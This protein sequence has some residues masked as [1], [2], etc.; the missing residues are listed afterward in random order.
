MIFH[1]LLKII[2]FSMF[3]GTFCW[4]KG[5]CGKE[6]IWHVLT[7]CHVIF[8]NSHIVHDL[9]NI[10]FAKKRLRQRIRIRPPEPL[11]HTRFDENH[12][13]HKIPPPPKTK[14]R[15]KWF[16][17][18]HKKICWFWCW[19]FFMIYSIFDFIL[20]VS[21]TFH[22]FIWHFPVSFDPNS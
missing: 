17:Y 19:Y 4:R 6:Y 22:F 10:Y 7:I 13:T 15:N 20:F 3:F 16:Y 11:N 8:R 18:I 5:A 2:I 14:I 1:G 21:F 12:K 9:L